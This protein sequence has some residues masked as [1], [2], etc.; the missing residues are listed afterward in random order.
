MREGKA[1]QDILPGGA[2][3]DACPGEHARRWKWDSNPVT[4][5]VPGCAA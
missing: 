2:P 5:G 3:V 1:L 4:K